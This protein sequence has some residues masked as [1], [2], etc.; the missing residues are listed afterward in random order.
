MPESMPDTHDA[1]SHANDNRAEIEAGGSCACFACYSTFGS[2]EVSKWSGDS[3][4]CPKCESVC[5]VLSESSGL[6]LTH[7]YLEAVHNHWIGSQ[8]TLDEVAKETHARA[9]AAL[10]QQAHSDPAPVAETPN[11]IKRFLRWLA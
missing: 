5:T 2:I 11:V 10:E 3:A 9:T 6:P 4:W 1:W 7:E 8:E